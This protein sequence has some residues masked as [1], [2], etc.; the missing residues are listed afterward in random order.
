MKL[1]KL[2]LP[3]L[4]AFAARFIP[5][6]ESLERSWTRW[7]GYPAFF[8]AALWVS[9]YLTFPSDA[10]RDRL[11][12]EARNRFDTEV[13]IGSVRPA[14]LSGLTLRDVSWQIGEA[15][16][17][18]APA[19]A[20]V[21][22]AA[23]EGAPAGEGGAPAPAPAAAAAPDNRIVLDRVTAKAEL[24][25]LLRGKKAFSFDVDA[26]GGN[27]EGRYETSAD[28][29]AVEA[30]LRGVDLGRSPL[31]PLAG[32]Q[33]DGKV[34]RADLTFASAAKDYAKANGKLTLKG[35]DLQLKGGEVQGVEL[36]AMA[37]G[38][39]DGNVTIENGKAT[40]ETFQ[41]KGQD[42]E[43]QIEGFVRL[44]AKLAGSTV[45]GKLKLKPSEEWWNRNE[46]LK[47]MANFALPAGKDGWR[48]VGLY[49]QL[50]H[51][52]FRPQR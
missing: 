39:L 48:S 41:L 14:G 20:P 15:P 32:I 3:K 34:A 25:A 23:P 11:A 47:G 30:Q 5:S 40:F 35:E 16:A 27:I 9:F 22:A 31:R 6:K 42:V 33:I 29:V 51:P 36:P 7:V 1:P 38:S 10:L 21:P 17:A 12:A 19:P 18:A 43:A 13:E 28:K 50:S 44:N 8:A 46:M 37:L 26:W 49:G 52:S 4:P 24:F 45:S 2:K